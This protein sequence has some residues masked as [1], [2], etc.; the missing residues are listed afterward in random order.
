MHRMTVSSKL[1][2]IGISLVTWSGTIS[3]CCSI[4]QAQ[5]TSGETSQPQAPKGS[6]VTPVKAFQNASPWRVTGQR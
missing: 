6:R 2:K 5:R 1:R 4:L 3:K